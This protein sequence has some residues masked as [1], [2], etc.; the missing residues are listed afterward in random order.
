MVLV[1]GRGQSFLDL[2]RLDRGSKPQ[3]CF[4]A[5]TCSYTCMYA[6][7]QLTFVDSAVDYIVTVIFTDARLLIDGVSESMCISRVF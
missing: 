7:T 1:L 4:H 5:Y 2:V 3:S 6:C